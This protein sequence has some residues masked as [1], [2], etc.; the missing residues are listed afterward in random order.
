ML[1]WIVGVWVCGCVGDPKIE[2]EF[3]IHDPLFP[4]DPKPKS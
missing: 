4:Q 3:T 2:S 1:G